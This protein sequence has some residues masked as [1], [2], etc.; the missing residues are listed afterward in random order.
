MPYIW[1]ISISNNTISLKNLEK[2][3]KLQTIQK[4]HPTKNKDQHIIH[5]S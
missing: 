3:G 1:G 2:E 4:H 5:K